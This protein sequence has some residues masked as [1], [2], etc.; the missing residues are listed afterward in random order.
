MYL[1]RLLGHL[2]AAEALVLLDKI[3]DAMEHL[4][5]ENVK[6]I[7]FDL[8]SDESNEVEDLVKAKPP[9]SNFIFEFLLLTTSIFLMIC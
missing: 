5:L 1:C 9:P 4:N 8:P 6:E 7:S 2:Y 3:G